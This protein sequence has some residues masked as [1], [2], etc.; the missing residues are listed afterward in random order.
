MPPPSSR[1]IVQRL[2][3][4]TKRCMCTFNII[5]LPF[6]RAGIVHHVAL[7]EHGV[8]SRRFGTAVREERE[9]EM[10]G[11][12]GVRFSVRRGLGRT[13]G[14]K[15]SQNQ[16]LYSSS[17]SSSCTSFV[18]QTNNCCALRDGGGG[19]GARDAGNCMHKTSFR[20]WR[21]TM[22]TVLSKKVGFEL[23]CSFN[24]LVSF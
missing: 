21:F 4:N 9:G 11:G 2:A 17:S 16:R 24:M 3:H 23:F 12:G 22:C 19:I 14:L 6:G 1:C 10:R 15:S 20:I 18:L 8:T 5:I 13:R 7:V